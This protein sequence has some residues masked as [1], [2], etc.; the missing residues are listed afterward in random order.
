LS[1][2]A[3]WL[4]VTLLGLLPIDWASSFA[5]RIARAIGPR[6]SA[7]NRA[8]RNL[9]DCFP[10]WDDARIEATVRDMWENF[11]RTAG[12]YPHL[13]GIDVSGDDPRVEVVGRENIQ[14]LRDDGLPG[15][16]FSA[17][18]GNWE[19][20]PMLS[21][22]NDLSIH[23]VYRAMNAPLAE[24][25]LRQ[26]VGR[27][28]DEMIPKGREG[29]IRM[30]RVLRKGGHLAIMIDQKLNKG[31]DVP[32]FGRPAK[33]APA[34]AMFA[35]KY[36]CPVVPARVER[37]AGARFR[38]T[39]WPPITLPDSGDAKADT[40]ALMTEVNRWVEGWV[41]DTPGQ[42]LWLHRRWGK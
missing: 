29:A 34:L 30:A 13:R 14:L 40:L 36:R 42:W 21:A 4:G 35:L 8:R 23:S 7:S 39:L 9:R 6:L 18:L 25:V 3:A 19:L 27:P 38:V 15:I 16:F 31:I 5:G 26:S 28:E 10:D 41:R 17:H 11:G 24:K 12:E 37:L 20:L 2:A 32:F 22:P 33:T 1:G